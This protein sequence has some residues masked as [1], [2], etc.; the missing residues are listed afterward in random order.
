VTFQA[1]ASFNGLSAGTYNIVVEDAN[2]CQLNGTETVNSLGG[3]TVDAISTTDVNCFGGND[4]NLTITASGTNPPFMYSI[5][6][7]NYQTSNSFS[8]LGAGNY[9]VSV[10][11]A[12]GCI[13]SSAS[14]IGEPTAIT[15]STTVQNENCNAQD[16]SI[17]ISAAGGSGTLNYSIDNANTFQSSSTFNNLS[18]GLYII[19]VEDGNACQTTII[20]TVFTN[21]GIEIDQ[22]VIN[23]ISCSGSNDGSILIQ[24]SGDTSAVSYSI[25][26]G[27]TSQNNPL[28]DN[29][30]PG[31][32]DIYVS[33]LYS[34]FDTLSVQ[35][36]EP[37]SLQTSLT[38]QPTNCGL[39]NGYAIVN[40]SGGTAP[41]SYQWD[42]SQ[43]Q[44][45]NAINNLEPGAYSVITTDA[46]G[47]SNTDSAGIAASDSLF[48]EYD[49]FNE[50]C[51]GL[52]DG[53][54]ATSASGGSAPYNY[55]WNTGD[56]TQNISGL[57]ANSY[58]LTVLDSTG[59]IA[60]AEILIETD[61]IDCII[62]PTV[63]SPNNDGSNDQWIIQGLDIYP[64]AQIEIYN[65]WGSLL[66]SSNSYQ[67]DWDG[68]RNG[69]QLPAG[70]YYYVV[71]ADEETTYTGSL[72]IMR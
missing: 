72:T 62:I 25:D 3:A 45:T 54:I 11:D 8:N 61:N 44:I 64:N 10:M 16:G 22:V 28:F 31:L 33:N 40:A 37:D 7:S 27:A 24:V 71:S 51:T 56:S 20:D 49:F 41:Y 21:D 30:A 59:C 65:R 34:C 48:I 63:I 60:N 57:S 14:V 53:S 2:G 70:V 55:L 29:L 67:N 58:M 39:N 18:A 38:V 12:N 4:G 13:S 15:V 68:M 32:F 9:T 47:C 6:G 5:D 26:G 46:N 1:S 52:S 17:T 50:S 66:F 69:K 19:V 42:D 23:D 43:S 35:V 36:A